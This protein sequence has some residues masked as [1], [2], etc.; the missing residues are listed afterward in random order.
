TSAPFGSSTTNGNIKLQSNEKSTACVAPQPDWRLF[1]WQID[2]DRVQVFDFATGECTPLQSSRETQNEEGADARE[3]ENK[4]PSNIAQASS[5]VVRDHYPIRHYWDLYDPRLLVVEAA[6]LPH[7][8]CPVPLA[9]VEAG[10]ATATTSTTDASSL[11]ETFETT[12]DSH[13][14]HKRP[15]SRISANSNSECFS[16]GP[17]KPSEMATSRNIV[18]SFFVSPEQNCMIVQESF[19]LSSHHASLIG[20]EVPYFYFSVEVG[21]A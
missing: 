21:S 5:E 11:D 2:S 14:Q 6:R 19:H 10:T 12:N 7:E 17:M 13:R 8:A 18:V 4:P 16:S 3:C 9:G 20:V 1:V 15:L